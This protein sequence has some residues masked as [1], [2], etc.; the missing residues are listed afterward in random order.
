MEPY[1][2]DRY[3]AMARAAGE[4]S[5]WYEHYKRVLL[6]YTAQKLSLHSPFVIEEARFPSRDLICAQ[7][8]Q[9]HV[10]RCYPDDQIQRDRRQILPKGFHPKWRHVHKS[11]DG[12]ACCF[13]CVDTPCACKHPGWACRCEKKETLE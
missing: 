3:E 2:I 8:A 6:L 9:W 12:A 13:I 11:L 5:F 4:Q 10:P 1:L 7:G